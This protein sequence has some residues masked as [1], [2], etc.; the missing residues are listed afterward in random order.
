VELEPR[1]S[2]R[3]AGREGNRDEERLTRARPRTEGAK[4]S[5]TGRAPPPTRPAPRG[6][7]HHLPDGPRPRRSW[8]A[9][10]AAGRGSLRGAGAARDECIAAGG[11]QVAH[12]PCRNRPRRR[13]ALR[14]RNR[15]PAGAT[16]YPAT[17]TRTEGL[18]TGEK[19]A[20]QPFGAISRNQRQSPRLPRN[21]GVP[22]SSPGVG[23]AQM[24]V[25]K[26]RARLLRGSPGPARA[27]FAPWRLGAGVPNASRRQ[28]N[29]PGAEI[30]QP[31]SQTSTSPTT[32]PEAS[33][34][35]NMVAPTISSAVP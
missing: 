1:E 10:M 23:S 24:P 9:E 8:C 6:G 29:D 33:E 11:P 12:A 4:Y 13:R 3:G 19:V 21:E 25:A 5:R 27:P 22:G 2:G 14:G 26:R 16:H 18:L 20:A 7:V 34:H 32:N 30:V 17:A 35:R 31:P 28:S 15:A